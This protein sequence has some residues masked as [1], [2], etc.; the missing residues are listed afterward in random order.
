MHF[1]A[2]VSS[3]SFKVIASLV[4]RSG[5]KDRT[6][7][8]TLQHPFENFLANRARAARE[9][10]RQTH[11]PGTH[12]ASIGRYRRKGFCL[13]G[14]L[15][16]GNFFLH[17][18]TQGGHDVPRTL[19]AISPSLCPPV[20]LPIPLLAG[21]EKPTRATPRCGAAL[22]RFIFCRKAGHQMVMMSAS[23]ALSRSST[24]LTYWLVSS[25]TCSSIRL[26]RSSG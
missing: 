6:R 20:S 25:C 2:A 4:S 15:S 23:F 10:F 21:P 17:P 13:R 3:W 14:H 26:P 24:F 9:K 22:V 18:A 8:F 11:L 12:H 5:C 7:F 1:S 19:H 16:K